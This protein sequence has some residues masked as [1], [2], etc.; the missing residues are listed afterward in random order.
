MNNKNNIFGF[1]AIP[2]AEEIA[3]LAAAF[4]K[5]SEDA[6]ASEGDA[7]GNGAAPPSPFPFVDTSR[8]RTEEPP[9]REWAV[10]DRIPRRQVALF[11]GEGAAG[12]STILLHECAAHVL[13]R[14]W[15]G[16]SPTPGPTFFID[17]E[18][19][20][21]EVWRRLGCVARHYGVTIADI[22][23]SGFKVASLFGDDALLA[24]VSKGGTITPTPRY[25][26]LFEAA[27]DIKPIMIGIASSACVFAGEENNRS[28]VQQFVGLLT[29]LAI[30]SNGAVQLI[31]HPSLT[32][33]NS[34]TGLSGT[35]QWHNAVRARSYLKGIK[36]ES[37]EQ[38]DNNLREIVFKKNQYGRIAESILLRYQDG[39]FLPLPG[40]GTLD[41]V[42]KAAAA[43]EV[44]AALLHR[45]DKE[46]RTVHDKPGPG[47][48]P[49]TFVGEAEVS[50]AGL[51]KKNLEAAMRELFRV[52]KIWNAPAPDWRP[53]RPRYKI[54]LK[55]NL[56]VSDALPPLIKHRNVDAARV[57]I[58]VLC[59]GRHA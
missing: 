37:G 56:R 23:D 35:T 53:S 48:A 12:K 19:D 46:N 14:D 32:G 57:L 26:A 44:F 13:M 22:L 5:T 45:Y 58:G 20:Q 10:P 1:E 38:P 7:Q 55:A 47:Y 36:P 4:H 6:K 25:H 41:Q 31:S 39:L 8:W 16:V 15:L 51:T 9:L 18:D 17:A 59:S 54:A 40:V 21:D 43:E 11:S 33:I 49:S 42:A 34:D 24:T 27:G 50:A 29:K 52:G 30:V 28:Q 2:D 3:A